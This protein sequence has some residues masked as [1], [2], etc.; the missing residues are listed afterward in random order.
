MLVRL[1]V[2]LHIVDRLVAE[3]VRFATGP[4]SR[5]NKLVREDL[6][7]MAARSRNSRK[8]RRK[9][10]TADAVRYILRQIKGLVD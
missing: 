1:R 8:S 9:Q 7:K 2:G 5:M 10:V 3:G 4:N 6:K